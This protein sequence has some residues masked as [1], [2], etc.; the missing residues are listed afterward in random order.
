MDLSQICRLVLLIGFFL[1]LIFS[2]LILFWPKFGKHRAARFFCLLLSVVY[3]LTISYF[4]IRNL[5]LPQGAVTN[6][7]IAEGL[8]TGPV[9]DGIPTGEGL[10]VTE[11]GEKIRGTFINGYAEGVGSIVLPDGGIY[12]GMLSK[13]QM[14]GEGY[15]VQTTDQNVTVYTGVFKNGVLEGNGSIKYADGSFYEGTILNL[16]P[17]GEGVMTLSDGSTYEGKFVC[18]LFHGAG[19]FTCKSCGHI[20]EGNFVCGAMDG[21]GRLKLKNGNEYSGIWSRD[22]FN[23]R[24]FWCDCPYYDSNRLL[25]MG[26]SFQEDRASFFEET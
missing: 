2:G 14:N 26:S 21:E 3:L 1:L 5:D 6:Y 13:N 11:S 9:I 25:A 24:L 12:N 7:E 23:K 17:N 15:L 20:Y 18:G 19:K 22:K 10:L 4:R 8:Y 16:Q